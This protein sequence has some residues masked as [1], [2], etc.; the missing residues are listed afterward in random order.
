MG[1]EGPTLW[2]LGPAG[3]FSDI[4]ADRLGWSGRRMYARSL[5]KLLRPAPR[6]VSSGVSILIPVRN[7]LIGAIPATA[8]FLKKTKPPVLA[9]FRV[10]VRMILVGRSKIPLSG[11]RTVYASPISAAQCKKFLKKRLGQAAIRIGFL[12]T[13]SA[14]KKIVQLRGGAASS[15]AA[16]GS[17]KAAKMHGLRVLARNIQDVQNNWTEFVLFTGASTNTRKKDSRRVRSRK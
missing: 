12:S 17:E 5:R 9:R 16:I 7:G 8:S 1:H 15:S 4:A 11:I 3:S 13:S 10:P 2:L 6:E 14:I